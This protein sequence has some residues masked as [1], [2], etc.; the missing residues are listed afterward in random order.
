MRAV[1]VV[2]DVDDVT[3]E[4]LSFLLLVETFDD[5]PLNKRISRY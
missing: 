2:K 3:L 5:I 1:E 4:Y